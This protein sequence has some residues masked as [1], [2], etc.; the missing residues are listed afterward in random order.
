MS[1]RRRSSW[2]TPPR[3]C[4]LKTWRTS[5]ENTN[6]VWLT[7]CDQ[8][9]PGT[10]LHTSQEQQ[11]SLHPPGLAASSRNTTAVQRVDRASHCSCHVGSRP[12]ELFVVAWC[13]LL[14]STRPP[15]LTLEAQLQSSPGALS[16]SH[17]G[18]APP[19]GLLTHRVHLCLSSISAGCSCTCLTVSPTSV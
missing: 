5:L 9:L 10:R 13:P 18:D 2:S 3:P 7:K 1:S 8:R 4:C 6:Q 16:G 19:L 11:S 14:L 12:A 17:P 15:R